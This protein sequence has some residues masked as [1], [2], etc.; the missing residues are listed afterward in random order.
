MPDLGLFSDTEEIVNMSWWNFHHDGAAAFQL[1]ERSPLPPA[2]S[3][4]DL[5]GWRIQVTDVRQITRFDC[6]PAETEEDCAPESISDT[7]NW[8]DWNGDLDNPNDR[9][10]D[11]EADN[12]SDIELNNC[13]EDLQ[14]S[15]QRDMSTAPNVPELI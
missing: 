4:N 15:E 12:E 8:H 5:P 11:W 1:S 10:D 3:P 6:H 2:L 7:K 13:N 9:D 14:L